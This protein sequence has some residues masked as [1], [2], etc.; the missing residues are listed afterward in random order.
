MRPIVVLGLLA[1]LASA[2]PFSK[3]PDVDAAV[4][5][6]IQDGQIPG[7]VVVVG[8]RGNVVYRKAYGNR[9]LIPAKEPMTVDTIFDCASLTKVVATTTAVLQLVEAGKIRLNDP[10]TRHLPEFQAGKSS[11]TIRNL[12]THFSGL[13]PD[14]DLE[15][16]WSGYE[17]GIRLALSD[18][19]KF[20]PGERFVYSDINYIL[21]GEIVRRLSGEPLP[22]YVRRILFEPLGMTDS[23]FQPPESLAR[24]I[25]PTERTSKNGPPLRGVVHDPTS[26]YMGGV[27]GHAGLYSTADDL[28]RFAQMMLNQGEW[29]GRRILSAGVIQ[30]AIE[31]QTPA[32]QPILRGLGWDIDSPF[33]GARG[34]LFP[35]G[36]YGHTGFTGTSL[37]I[38]PRSQAYVILLTNAVHPVYRGGPITS[39]R[40]RVSTIVA[41]AV[42][43]AGPG[44]SLTGYNETISG[45]GIRRAVARNSEVLTGLDVLVEQKFAALQGKRV[46]LITNHTGIDRDGRRNVDRMVDAGVNVVSLFAPEHGFFGAEDQE[47]INHSTDPKTG[48][49]IW[50]LYAGKTRR[51]ARQ[52]LTGLDVLVFDIQDIGSRFYTYVSTMV[53]SM[54]E[55]AKKRIAFYV[56]DRPNPISGVKVEGPVLDARLE[57]FVGCFPMP[58]RHGMTLGELARMLNVERA[59]DVNLHVVSMKNWERGDWFDSTGQLWVNP[60]PNMRSLSAATLYPGIAM[61]EASRNYSVG[62]GTD[63]P[64]EIVGAEFIHGR[65]L[66]RYLNQRMIPGIRVY[67]TRFKPATSVLA[68]KMIEGVRFIVTDRAALNSAQLGIELAA[69]LIRLYPGKIDFKAN[70]KL[71]GNRELVELLQA[72]EDPRSIQQKLE[73]P[74]REFLAVRDKYLLYR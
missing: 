36:S 47:N 27:A 60:S 39:L 40:G 12:M 3:G 20:A 19:P 35:V 74:L 30:K 10:V 67:P 72:G 45:A 21:L 42:G 58:T 11:I 29:N 46:G 26:R 57:S 13:R 43:V 68:G 31:P 24:R 54:E 33:S 48:I 23:L 15:P 51:P 22:D 6:A 44:V 4:E 56:L 73:E 66:A 61:L 38:D 8:H 2:Q 28:A 53:L 62:R 63:T 64:F 71:I 32:D 55:A 7:A 52:M 59:V 41:A 17:T 9:A 70:L 14:L 37:W 16:A 1:Q 34:D 5:G 49:R 18:K 25:A 65:M 50:S 69:A